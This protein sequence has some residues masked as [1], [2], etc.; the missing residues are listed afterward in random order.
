[1]S[2]IKTEVLFHEERR[3]SENASMRV[4]ARNLIVPKEIKIELKQRE[5]DT[6]DVRAYIQQG[7]L[8]ES[9]PDPLSTALLP[10]YWAAL[11]TPVRS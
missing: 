3:I 5:R 6:T 10:Q 7:Q 4:L 2:L 1:M 9:R 8:D 11:S